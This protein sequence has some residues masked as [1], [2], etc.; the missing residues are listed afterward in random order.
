MTTPRGKVTATT[1][2]LE[3]VVAIVVK[4]GESTHADFSYLE[5]QSLT[6]ARAI[7][8]KNSGPALRLGQLFE[9]SL[10]GSDSIGRGYSRDST[11]TAVPFALKMLSWHTLPPA[12]KK[13]VSP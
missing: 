6:K 4:A 9:G 2:G 12:A 1:V 7:A 11:E 8:R 3:H 13:P 5:Q 10:Y